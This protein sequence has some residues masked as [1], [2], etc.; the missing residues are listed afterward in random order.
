MFNPALERPVLSRN[1]CTPFAKDTL[2]WAN[3]DN[4]FPK[5]ISGFEADNVSFQMFVFSKCL[6]QLLLK[7]Y[8]LLCNHHASRKVNFYTIIL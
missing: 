5:I 3:A 2:L 7:P 8:P 1:L 6:S 4:C